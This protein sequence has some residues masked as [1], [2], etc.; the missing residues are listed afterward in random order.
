LQADYGAVLMVTYSLYLTIEKLKAGFVRLGC[1]T[2]VFCENQR[3]NP[4][5]II[6]NIDNGDGTGE[7]WLRLPAIRI[8]LPPGYY[9]LFVMR[10]AEPE[11]SWGP[12]WVPSQAVY[13]RATGRQLQIISP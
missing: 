3:Y 7:V 6:G 9:M 12:E 5:S 13:V 1:V 10:L 2:H 4:L 8:V 11:P